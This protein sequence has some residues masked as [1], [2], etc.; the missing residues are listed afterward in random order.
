MYIILLV[1]M[2]S[3]VGVRRL[4]VPIENLI[5]NR[6][7][8][9]RPA[10]RTDEPISPI[11]RIGSGRSETRGVSVLYAIIILCARPNTFSLLAGSHGR[12]A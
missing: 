9:S 8:S 6:R 11:S 4:R 12:R 3:R 7:G 2:Q 1:M 10:A 5:I